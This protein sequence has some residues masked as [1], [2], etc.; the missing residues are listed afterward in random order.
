MRPRRHSA[1]LCGPSTS[2]LD[3]HRTPAI[4]TRLYDSM[5]QWYRRWYSREG[6]VRAAAATGLSLCMLFNLLFVL[7]VAALLSTPDVLLALPKY[8]PLLLAAA[9][10]I[11]NLAYAFAPNSRQVAMPSGQ[12]TPGLALWYFAAS[13]LT[14]VLSFALL[15]VVRPPPG[16]WH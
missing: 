15:V 6:Y 16:G 4:Y 1:L 7:N 2:P 5:C 10:W 13:F 3:V 11:A 14:L 8:A 9:L 12:A